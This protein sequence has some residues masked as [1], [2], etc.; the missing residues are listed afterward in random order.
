M[1][2][3]GSAIIQPNRCIRIAARAEQSS[4]LSRRLN[5]FF[6]LPYKAVFRI[7]DILVWIRI[8]GS[9]PLTNGSGFG[10]SYFFIDLQDANKK[11]ILKSF[12]AYYFLKV[13]LH[14]FSKRK[15]SKRSHKTVENKV[16]VFLTILIDDRT[17]QIREAQKHV[18]PDPE[19]CYKGSYFVR[20]VKSS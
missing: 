9:M 20:L 16:F 18:D 12:S 14:H 13:H 10:S 11:L 8:R 1:E 6:L 5:V 3:M 7:Y 17:I 4:T 15:K 19:Q 2:Q